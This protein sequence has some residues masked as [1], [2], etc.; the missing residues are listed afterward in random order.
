MY[1]P[2]LC[3]QINLQRH[4]GAISFIVR[5]ECS[6]RSDLI[7]SGF[8]ARANPTNLSRYKIRPRAAAYDRDR[9]LIAP[10][11]GDPVRRGGKKNTLLIQLWFYDPASNHRRSRHPAILAPEK[12][13]EAAPTALAGGFPLI[14][15]RI[16]V[17]E[18]QL[19]EPPVGI[20]PPMISLRKRKRTHEGRGNA[21]IRMRYSQRL[22]SLT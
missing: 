8:R 6:T 2:R 1:M 10:T 21:T 17:R 15:R 16:K 18:A 9:S 3:T 7:S 19:Y 11:R 14:Y 22:S 5:R 20:D 12:T 4:S 13:H